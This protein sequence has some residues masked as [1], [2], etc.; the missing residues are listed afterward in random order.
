MK[1]RLAAGVLVSALVAFGASGCTFITPQATLDEVEV[2]NGVNGDAGHIAVRNATLISNNNGK[3]ASLLSSFVNVSDRDLSLT[4][5]WKDARGQETTEQ[6]YIPAGQSKSLGAKEEP[7]LIL[8]D[9]PAPAGS[10]F[11]IYFQSG[12]SPGKELL[13]PVLTSQWE[14]YDGLAPTVAPTAVPTPSR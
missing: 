11:P 1:A 6:V 10:L 5:Q 2:A 12:D 4:I 7:Q 14:E 3:T 13:V 9:I 8:T